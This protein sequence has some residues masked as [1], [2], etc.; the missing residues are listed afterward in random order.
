MRP[1]RRSCASRSPPARQR[2]SPISS[3]PY[4]TRTGT[5]GIP[6][7]LG[8]AAGSTSRV[9]VSRS[10]SPT[11]PPLQRTQLQRRI[12]IAG[13]LAAFALGL[14]FFVPDHAGRYLLG[15]RRLADWTEHGGAG[16]PSGP[17]RGAN[18]TAYSRLAGQ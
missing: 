4:S 5:R 1:A 9:W 2:T 7:S 12:A 11:G 14:M 6:V 17:G 10:G 8:T 13:V 15:H 3:K 16:G 18:Q